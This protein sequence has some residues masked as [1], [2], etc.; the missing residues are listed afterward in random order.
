MAKIV[1]GRT[2][3]SAV[4]GGPVVTITTSRVGSS[5]LAAPRGS[6]IVAT[7]GPAGG[8]KHIYEVCQRTFCLGTTAARPCGLA[9]QKL[10]R[11]PRRPVKAAGWT[12]TSGKAAPGTPRRGPPR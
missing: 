7:D 10:L 12:W 3:S 1:K 5:L 4:F 6:V 2:L 9:P 8:A 11:T